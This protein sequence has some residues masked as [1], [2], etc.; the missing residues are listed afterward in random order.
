MSDILRV[1]VVHE[2]SEFVYVFRFECT[3][4]IFEINV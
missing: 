1:T 2:R 4:T 3:G